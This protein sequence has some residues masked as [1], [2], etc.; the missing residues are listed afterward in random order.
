MLPYLTYLRTIYHEILV[1]SRPGLHE[2]ITY[3]GSYNVVL[4]YH[5]QVV[6]SKRKL[7]VPRETKRKTK[8]HITRDN[9]MLLKSS[10]V[11]M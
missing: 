2:Q 3:I 7:G 6:L 10:R 1:E 8:G 4:R 11:R 5:R 9:M